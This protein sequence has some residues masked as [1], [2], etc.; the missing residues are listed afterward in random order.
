M[1][2]WSGARRLA[3]PFFPGGRYLVSCAMESKAI[4]WDLK[5]GRPAVRLQGVPPEICAGAVLGDG[6]IVA[7]AVSDGRV[8]SWERA[9]Q[10]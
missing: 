4:V 9:H 2:I 6:A 3:Q 1:A 10:P 8:R 7:A 5:S